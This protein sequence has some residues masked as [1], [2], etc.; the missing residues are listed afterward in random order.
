ME[1]LFKGTKGKWEVNS[2]DGKYFHIDVNGERL[3]SFYKPKRYT[4]D[5]VTRIDE[6]GCEVTTLSDEVAAKHGKY[7]ATEEVKKQVEKEEEANAYL[8]A[9]APELLEAAI[10]AWIILS[11]IPEE[12]MDYF[13]KRAVVGLRSAINKALNEESEVSN[14]Q[15]C[16]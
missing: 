5:Y 14:E 13:T 3:L 1:N 8:V 12:V 2:T 9:A 10:K 7:V 11:D 16:F 4:T 6:D 15:L